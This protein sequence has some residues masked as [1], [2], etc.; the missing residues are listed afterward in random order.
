MKIFF[1]PLP[2]FGIAVVA[3]LQ[4]LCSGAYAQGYPSKPVKIMVPYS[5]GGT[6]DVLARQLA[7]RLQSTWG[8]GVVVEN[9]TGASGN[10]GTEVVVKSPADGYT[11]VI[12][13]NTM[14]VSE[15]IGLKANFDI[16]K[17]LTP[18]MLLGQTPAIIVSHPR[19][20]IKSL[21]DLMAYTKAHPGELSYASCGI[22]TPHHMIMELLKLRTHMDITHVSYR[23]CAPG[24]VDVM[25]GQI[26]LAIVSANLSAVPTLEEQGQKG[27][28]ITNW[29]ALMGPA[30]LPT[31]VI[32][33]VQGDVN[34]LLSDKAL[35][36][37]LS[38]AG[39][40]AYSGSDEDLAKLI[41]S[42][43][44]RYGEIAKATKIRAE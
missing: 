23:G 7:A 28:A 11:L 15:A 5:A 16:Q 18:I 38:D 36:S 44:I 39:V 24:V 33:R 32:A 12:Q 35:R 4:L 8:Q 30:G 29:F 37:S 25:G 13:N 34:S 19:Y 22:G 31:Q 14:V 3:G 9:R 43:R 1:S 26:P 27:L 2:L 21:A 41:A 42:E 40:E 20:N 10:I 6:G 17:D